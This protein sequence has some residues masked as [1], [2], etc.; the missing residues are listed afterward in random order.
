MVVDVLTLL[1]V[2]VMTAGAHA[3]H[4]A[5]SCHPGWSQQQS[6]AAASTVTARLRTP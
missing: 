6:S 4:S 3:S 1:I 5:Q 2:S